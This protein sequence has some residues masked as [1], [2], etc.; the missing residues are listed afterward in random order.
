MNKA[1]TAL[2][3]RQKINNVLINLIPSVDNETIS[4]MMFSISGKCD[5]CPIEPFYCFKQTEKH[6]TN[7]QEELLDWL[8]GRLL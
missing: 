4:E 2:N 8:E 1:F 7:C 3:K 6:S 5:V